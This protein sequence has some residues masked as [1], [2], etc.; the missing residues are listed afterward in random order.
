M[1]IRAVNQ[2]FDYEAKRSINEH[3]LRNFS[4]FDIGEQA[5]YTGYYWQRIIIKKWFAN[6]SY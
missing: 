2:F 4:K 5:F 6:I 1:L 3:I